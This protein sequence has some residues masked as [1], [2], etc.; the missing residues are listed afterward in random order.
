MVGIARTDP[1]GEAKEIYKAE[2]DICDILPK[3]ILPTKCAA[4]RGSLEGPF[5]NLGIAN[6]NNLSTLADLEAKVVGI[7]FVRS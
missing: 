1:P 6:M 4:H 7:S 3:G 5:L 2:A